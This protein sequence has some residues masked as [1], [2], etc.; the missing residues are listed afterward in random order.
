VF[1]WFEMVKSMEALNEI[2]AFVVS[3]G[4]KHQF[5]SGLPCFSPFQTIKTLI[6]L[7]TSLL[8]TA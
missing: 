7:R 1:L 3:S 4:G 6:S 5:R 8:S 2:G